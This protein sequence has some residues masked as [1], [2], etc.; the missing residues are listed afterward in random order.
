MKERFRKI[1]KFK[2]DCNGICYI[3]F[4]LKGKEG[5]IDFAIM[6][7]LTVINDEV[8]QKYELCNWSICYHSIKR[9]NENDTVY[10]KC[11]FLNNKKCYF[12][13]ISFVEGEKL[14]KLL[15][16]NGEKAVFEELKKFYYR[17]FCKEKKYLI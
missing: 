17:I 15:I 1:I 10:K 5:A 11:E 12:S 7:G 9:I 4:V 13:I 16:T 6:T 3:I 14:L 2:Q 8:K